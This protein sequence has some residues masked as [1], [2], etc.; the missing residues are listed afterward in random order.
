MKR[1]PLS[2]IVSH[3]F[4]DTC[5]PKH[6]SANPYAYKL[7]ARGCNHCTKIYQE[8]LEKER[9]T[10]E[11]QSYD[12]FVAHTLC[13]PQ[14]LEE[15]VNILTMLSMKFDIVTILPYL[16]TFILFGIILQCYVY[17]GYTLVE[18]NAS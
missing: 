9:I 4:I 8:A 12:L 5:P 2:S 6:G 16:L 17:K 10:G 18:Y 3:V 11:P 13:D 15:K 1:D 14:E 7:Q